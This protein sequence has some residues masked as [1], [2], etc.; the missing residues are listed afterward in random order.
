MDWRY[1][2]PGQIYL[3]VLL[4]IIIVKD[5][6]HSSHNLRIQMVVRRENMIVFIS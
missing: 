2:L 3:N 1:S 4:M 5:I 6:F